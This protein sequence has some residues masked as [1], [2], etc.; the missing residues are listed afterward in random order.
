MASNYAYLVMVNG[1]CGSNNNKFYEITENSDGS[2]DVKYGR[3]GKGE[4]FQHYEHNERTFYG[5]MDEKLR[6]G[7]EDK[8]ALHTKVSVN[9]TSKSRE[10]SCKPV[11][12]KDVQEFLDLIISASREFFSQ[13]YIIKPTDITEKM[14]SEAQKDLYALSEIALNPNKPCSLY[15]FNKKLEELFSDVPRRMGRVSDYLAASERDFDRIIERETDM[16]N[17]VKGNLAKTK[18]PS[19][20]INDNQTV[21]EMYGLSARP[22]T[23]R[24]EDQ[25]VAH[26]GRDYSGNSVESRYIKAFAVENSETRAAF[27]A[28]K[29]EKNIS[30]S[31]VKLLYHGTKTENVYSIMKTGLCLNPNASVTGKM[32]G[33]G[34]Y[35]A[36]DSRKSA[37]YADIKGSIWRKGSSNDVGVLLVC[38]VALGNTYKPNY[39][40]GAAF[41]ES[42]LPKGKD[43]VYAS[44][45][46]PNLGLKNDEYIVY[47]EAA[48]TIKYILEISPSNVRNKSY[49]L[50]RSMLRD[51]LA[52]GF[53]TLE[54]TPDGLRAELE[55]EKLSPL[56]QSV[57]TTQLADNFSH[58]YFDLNSKNDRLSI[59]IENIDGTSA[60][61]YPDITSDDYAFLARE[62]KKTF[63][64]SE[65]EWNK[66]KENSNEYLT[67]EIVLSKD[68]IVGKDIKEEKKTIEKE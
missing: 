13:N 64:A 53:N 16:L 62:M 39:V 5:L 66:I 68:G 43:S 6:K 11:E 10:M 7:Y 17:N 44:K 36:S 42:N 51:K 63:A 31:G 4:R 58:L 28:Y 46:N 29:A 57:I 2:L 35:F 60:T 18:E 27:E 65:K 22:V 32:F 24:E 52:D 38:S 55:V 3:I 61:L 25:I 14:V 40:L 21:L 49:N 33:Q 30:G 20:N 9:E 59:S 45:H 54:K 34:I 47:N 67:G 50:D 41:C 15:Y 12:D 23:Y 1:S 48:C 26:L 37:N 19:R 56:V 8:T